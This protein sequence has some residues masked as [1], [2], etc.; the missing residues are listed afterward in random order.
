M[1]LDENDMGECVESV[2]EYMGMGYLIASIK[3]FLCITKKTTL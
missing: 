2:M 3:C 1:A